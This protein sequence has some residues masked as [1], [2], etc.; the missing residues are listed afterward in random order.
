MPEICWIQIKPNLVAGVVRYM[1]L[2]FNYS[3][4]MRLGKLSC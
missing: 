1:D 3:R 2:E 4:V